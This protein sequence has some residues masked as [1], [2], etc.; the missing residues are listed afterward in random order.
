MF[1]Q[2]PAI[3]GQLNQFSRM[4]Q[5]LAKLFLLTFFSLTLHAADNPIKGEELFKQCIACHTVGKGAAHGVGP[6]LNHVFG[7]IAGQS[8]GYEHYS[9]AMTGKGESD[10]LL[11]DEKSLY[12]FLAGPARYVPGT[13]MGF[14]GL[15]RE[16][17]IKDLLSF[18]IQFSP[19]YV[20]K[21]GEAVD[22][23]VAAQTE[24]PELASS[25]APE[26]PA[27]TDDYLAQTDAIAIGETLW[28]KQCRH[29][30]GSSAYP[31]KAPKLKPVRYNP[32]FVFD[33]ITDGFRKM[34][35][36]KSVFSLDERKSL[37]A[38][39]LSDEF[40]P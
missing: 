10:K 16:Q 2:L 13:T 21:S 33:R 35:A 38:Y 25:D 31:G 32:E 5:H 24:L 15:R 19:A 20:A 28:A 26:D 12:I 34:P 23:A 9:E 7:R 22:P 36:W 3:S 40:S 14:E 37:V 29:C 27:F 17:E 8:E 4:K 18:L 39:I 1:N 11:W 6:T 30:H